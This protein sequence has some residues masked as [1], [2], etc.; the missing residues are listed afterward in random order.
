MKLSGSSV[1]VGVIAATCVAFILAIV[2]CL[3][4]RLHP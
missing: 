2:F 3:V 1:R 4:P